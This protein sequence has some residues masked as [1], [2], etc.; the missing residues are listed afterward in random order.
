MRR[1]NLGEHDE[2]ELFIF[3]RALVFVLFCFL[4]FA[5]RGRAKLKNL[6]TDL[7]TAKGKN[8]VTNGVIIS[9]LRLI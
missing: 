6:A 7:G 1:F 9:L 5:R 2:L 8:E 3:L 4:F